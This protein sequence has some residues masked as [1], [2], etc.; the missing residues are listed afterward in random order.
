MR[1]AAIRCV[2]A[3]IDNSVSGS[4]A[5]KRGPVVVRVG[6]SAAASQLSAR[7]GDSWTVCAAH[8]VHATALERTFG[9]L[10]VDVR[11][12]VPDVTSESVLE[13]GNSA[14]NGG[15]V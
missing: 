15:G 11:Q 13:L 3:E 6:V 8:Q 7:A 4:R 14:I 2:L 10:A 5:S 12:V 9:C 1:A